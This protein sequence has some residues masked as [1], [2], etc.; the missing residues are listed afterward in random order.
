MA[1]LVK[2]LYSRAIGKCH[3]DQI[4]PVIQAA[5]RNTV[6]S[7]IYNVEGNRWHYDIDDYQA[8]GV[9][10]NPHYLNNY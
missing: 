4:T 6:K 3:N 5:A 2:N 7:W 1:G 9:M 8:K 10:K